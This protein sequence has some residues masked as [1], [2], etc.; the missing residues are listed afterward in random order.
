L[1]L[2][3]IILVIV[4]VF[5]RSS[6]SRDNTKGDAPPKQVEF[7]NPMYSDVH[8]DTDAT[9]GENTATDVVKHEG[10]GEGAYATLP[11]S[12]H[13]QAIVYDRAADGVDSMYAELGKVCLCVYVCVCVCE[14]ERERERER[15]CVCVC[16]RKREREP[17]TERLRRQIRK[18]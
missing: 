13:S 9:Y 6:Q 14:R 18:I 8:T 15:A 16:V 1:F 17:E 7:T 4:I 2:V 12:T 11:V 5:Q 10:G 3:I